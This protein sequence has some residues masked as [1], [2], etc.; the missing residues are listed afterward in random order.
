MT[1]TINR[2][3]IVAGMA[4]AA[5]ASPSATAKQSHH[6]DRTLAKAFARWLE[7]EKVYYDT[8][9]DISDKMAGQITDKQHPLEST[10]ATTPADTWA[11]V[12]CKIDWLQHK[13][14]IHF[15][16]TGKGREVLKST[17]ADVVRLSA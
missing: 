7:A 6:N 11:G 8:P 13:T 1:N 15:V 17:F 3:T 9:D 10:L 16:N 2:R 4:T 5:I 14:N 12:R